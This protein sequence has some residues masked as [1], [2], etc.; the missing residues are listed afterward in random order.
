MLRALPLS[1]HSRA[2]GPHSGLRSLHLWGGESL[3]GPL[4][5]PSLAQWMILQAPVCSAAWTLRDEDIRVHALP[6]GLSPGVRLLLPTTMR[7]T[8][9]CLAEGGSPVFAPRPSWP[10]LGWQLQLLIGVGTKELS[11]LSVD[12]THPML[13]FGSD[14]YRFPKAAPVL[15]WTHGDWDPDELLGAL[16]PRF[17]GLCN[18][19]GSRG[20]R[21][22]MR[23]PWPVAQGVTCP[24]PAIPAC[25]LI[26]RGPRDPPAAPPACHKGLLELQ[27]PP[28]AGGWVIAAS[29]YALRRGPSPPKVTGRLWS[30]PSCLQGAGRTVTLRRADA[31]AW[32]PESCSHLHGSRMCARRRDRALTG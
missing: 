21:S 31:L 25:N 10:G 13:A 22:P 23:P 11:P 19:C 2:Q 17:M 6:R 12:G 4:G 30:R 18:G 7:A 5:S 3:K 26:A 8:G 32:C 27:G 1:L 14:S 28:E 15:G 29:L 16:G 24:E 9:L 20:R